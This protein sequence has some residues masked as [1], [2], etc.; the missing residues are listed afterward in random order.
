MEIRHIMD[1]QE[2]MEIQHIMDVQDIMEIQHI[3]DVHEIMEIQRHWSK[4]FYIYR[5]GYGTYWSYLHRL[6]R[7]MD[8]ASLQCTYIHIYFAAVIFS[9]FSISRRYL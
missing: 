1:V 3:M 6:H 8:N 4:I 2:I 5:R 9:Q 7:F